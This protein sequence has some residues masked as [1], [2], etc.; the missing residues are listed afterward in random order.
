MP[1]NPE[2]LEDLSEAQLERM[3]LSASLLPGRRAMARV[4]AI[5]TVLKRRPHTQ[6]EVS[7]RDARRALELV[8]ATRGP[9]DQ[10]R[11]QD[12]H[13]VDVASV[14]SNEEWA[15]ML[16]S[17]EEMRAIAARRARLLARTAART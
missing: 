5:R 10:L 9:D 12:L 11:L 8:N 1:E 6:T 15:E 7:E 13:P 4:T 16:V 3:L 17:D 14:L 2:D